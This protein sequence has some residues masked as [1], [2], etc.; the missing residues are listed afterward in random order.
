MAQMLSNLP[1]NQPDP[2]SLQWLQDQ[3]AGSGAVQPMR[4]G[5]S[6][7]GGFGQLPNAPGPPDLTGKGLAASQAA[8]APAGSATI[9]SLQ[10]LDNGGSELPAST[11]VGGSDGSSVS[12]DIQALLNPTK[13]R[14]QP[15]A[16]GPA[17][18]IGSY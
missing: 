11:G 4:Q 2:K 12:P 7:G 9:A 8:N 5:F 14:G 1:G 3:L 17:P 10:G 15:P 13:K 6:Y 18:T 16:A